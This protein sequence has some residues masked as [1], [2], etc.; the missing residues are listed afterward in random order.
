MQNKACISIYKI[1]TK[2]NQ[3][4]YIKRL[5]VNFKKYLI[6]GIPSL[7]PLAEIVKTTL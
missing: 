4:Q 3:D 2:D 5:Q 1:Y 7:E 6:Y